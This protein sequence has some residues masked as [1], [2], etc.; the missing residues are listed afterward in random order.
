MNNSLYRVVV[1]GPIPSCLQCLS[2]VKHSSWYVIQVINIRT[3]TTWIISR[4][5]PFAQPRGVSGGSSD[6]CLGSPYPLTRLTSV[7]LSHKPQ[8]AKCVQ[9]VSQ[10]VCTYT[11]YPHTKKNA[12]R[13]LLSILML[14]LSINIRHASLY[15][16]PYL[17]RPRKMLYDMLSLPCRIHWISI[18]FSY[19]FYLCLESARLM[20]KVMINIQIQL[21]GS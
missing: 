18:H 12:Q 4:Y 2:F 10:K 3:C 11:I 6:P 13:L 14:I 1:T 15:S 5:V 20:H 7:I 17:P 16:A 9:Y 21:R 8:N 19:T